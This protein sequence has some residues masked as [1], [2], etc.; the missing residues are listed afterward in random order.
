[1]P[2]MQALSLRQSSRKFDSARLSEQEPSDLLWAAD[3]INRP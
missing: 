3:G 1:M 2:L